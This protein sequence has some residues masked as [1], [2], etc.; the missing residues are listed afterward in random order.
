VLVELKQPV[1]RETK[2]TGFRH[3]RRE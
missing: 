2:V 3:G 1:A